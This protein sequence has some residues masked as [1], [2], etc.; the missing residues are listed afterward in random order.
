MFSEGVHVL[1]LEN[2]TKTKFLLIF[3]KQFYVFGM[4]SYILH[5]IPICILFVSDSWLLYHFTEWIQNCKGVENTSRFGLT[6]SISV[7][8]IIL[9]KMLRYCYYW[10]SD[11]THSQSI[12]PVTQLQLIILWPLQLTLTIDPVTLAIHPFTLAIDPAVTLAIDPLTL[13]VIDLLTPTIDPVTLAVDPFIL[14]IDM[15]SLTIDPV[16]LAIDPAI[17]AIDL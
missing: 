11:E 12:H 10:F 7:L 3:V 5:T 8:M 17:P 9:S 4:C 13:K 15:V 1:Y 16:T 6:S 14:A 2:P